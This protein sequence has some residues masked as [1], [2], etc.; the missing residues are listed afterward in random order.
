LSPARSSSGI[1]NRF[2]RVHRQTSMYLRTCCNA[3]T[4]RISFGCAM[5]CPPGLLAQLS[6]RIPRCIPS[7]AMAA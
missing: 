4:A 3:C 1:G 7:C 2:R 6:Q 5:A